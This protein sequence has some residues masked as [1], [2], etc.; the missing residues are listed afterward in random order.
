MQSIPDRL[1]TIKRLIAVNDIFNIFTVID[2]PNGVLCTFRKFNKE[3]EMNETK[4]A[5]AY[6]ANATRLVLFSASGS[7]YSNFFKYILKASGNTPE[8]ISFGELAFPNK[9]EYALERLT[10]VLENMEKYPRHFLRL[11]E[12]CSKKL[13]KDSPFLAV[14]PCTGED[15]VC[16][17]FNATKEVLDALM[18]KVD[19][20][21]PGAIKTVNGL[22]PLALYESW[23]DE[24]KMLLVMEQWAHNFEAAPK[25]LETLALV[26]MFV[27]YTPFENGIWGLNGKLEVLLPI[28]DPKDP[29]KP[30]VYTKTAEKLVDEVVLYFE[31][32][33]EK[34]KYNTTLDCFLGYGAGKP[35][36]PI[37]TVI[38]HLF[39]KI[40]RG[41][42]KLQSDGVFYR[43]SHIAVAC[44]VA[45]AAKLEKMREEMR[46][47]VYLPAPYT[48]FEELAIKENPQLDH[49]RQLE[50]PDMD[51]SI[52]MERF[53]NEKITRYFLS[54]LKTELSRRVHLL[55][56]EQRCVKMLE[57][58]AKWEAFLAS[59]KG[60][61]CE[62]RVKLESNVK[63]TKVTVDCM[64]AD[65]VAKKL[66]LDE[67]AAKRQVKW[68]EKILASSDASEEESQ[69]FEA[70]DCPR[71]AQASLKRPRED[72]V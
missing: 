38:M 59:D 10:F 13:R 67:Q 28:V 19:P 62:N 58:V 11:A 27:E 30:A 29:A 1:A 39:I 7:V 54:G 17:F 12:D 16:R 40:A 69:V 46:N 71:E 49:I 48:T 45:C 15:D 50:L 5:C 53:E 66:A 64:R 63:E 55:E 61:T 26:D 20:T 47:M 6:C 33:E 3:T 4:V 32:V 42:S 21:K 37:N 68:N 56:I 52:D 72:D 8:R 41:E 14:P 22:L 44:R 9:G 24:I 70:E 23:F 51:G 2:V 25:M 57:D 36:I 18:A 34:V 43:M 65:N 31:E 60:Q 35:E